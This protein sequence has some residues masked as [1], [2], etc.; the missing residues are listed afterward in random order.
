VAKSSYASGQICI[1]DHVP[2]DANWTTQ[3]VERAPQLCSI[4]VTAHPAMNVNRTFAA[5]LPHS[6]LNICESSVSPKVLR[7]L[8]SERT[9]GARLR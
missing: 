8:L 3:R 6:D 9:G 7:E 2:T 5:N 1:H 4:R